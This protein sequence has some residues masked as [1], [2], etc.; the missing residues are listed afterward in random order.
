[1]SQKQFALLWKTLYD[2]FETDQKIYHSLSV[3]GESYNP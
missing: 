3:T 2:F 1:M